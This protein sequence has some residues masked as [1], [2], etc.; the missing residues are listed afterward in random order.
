MTST[1]GTSAENDLVTLIV[2]RSLFYS[3]SIVAGGLLVMS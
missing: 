3:H 2:D 1:N